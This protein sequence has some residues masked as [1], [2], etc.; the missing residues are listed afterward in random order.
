MDVFKVY[1]RLYRIY[2]P[3]GWWP[4]I[5]NTDKNCHDPYFEIAVGAILT[6]NTAW[7][8][9]AKAISNLHQAEPLKPE[10][11]LKLNTRKLQ[12][13]IR[14]AGYYKQKTKKLK[15]FCRWLVENYNG[16]LTKLKK[17]QIKTVRAKLLDLWGIGKETADSIILYALNKP[18]FV[19]DEYT[20][21]LCH[22]YNI[23]FPEYDDYRHFFETN[24]KKNKS[25]KLF[26]EYH[27]L[28][29]ASGK[30]KHKHV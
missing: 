21:R 26:Q 30:E 14:P 28:L 5:G 15:I 8:N 18:I 22:A 1:K 4:I 3:Q 12:T 19:I 24:L 29:V 17:Y 2:G 10:L 11:I 27:A 6:Q 13:L 9:V 7:K 16:D 20:R 25:A 23:S